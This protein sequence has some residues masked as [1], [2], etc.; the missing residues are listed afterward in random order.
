M[1]GNFCHKHHWWDG[2][3]LNT[4]SGEIYIEVEWSILNSLTKR[5]I[6]T[7]STS[8]YAVQEEPI[9]GGIHTAFST[10]FA[11]AA[12]SFAAEDTVISLATGESIRDEATTTR[13]EAPQFGVVSGD[14][15]DA[16]DIDDVRRF[17]ATIRIGQG[18]GSGFFIGSDGHVLTNAHVVG[19]AKRVQVITASG[20]EFEGVVVSINRARDVAMLK[21]PMSTHRPTPLNVL[22]PDVADEV[23]AVGTP[24][25][26]EL[27][28]TVTS[29][30]VS[31]MRV[32]RASNQQFIQADVA[33]SP[34]NSGGP[35]LDKGG[36]V[37]G[38]SVAKYSGSGAE[39]LGLF[40][41]LQDALSSLGITVD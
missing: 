26:E 29:G 22:L 7:S 8:G 6:F 3:P 40:I 10:A 14:I 30:I 38:L 31:A 15:S 20:M 16:F 23:Y 1:K 41:P 33:I 25:R 34:G 36:N 39:N 12:D 24:I 4:Y 19:E 11:S 37:I 21:T 35:L 32:D 2:R 28:L 18:H 5:V 27:E 17:V 9:A 13:G